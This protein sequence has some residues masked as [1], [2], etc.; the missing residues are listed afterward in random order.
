MLRF[1][2]FLMLPLYLFSN[3]LIID[4]KSRYDN[5]EISYLYDSYNHLHIE[6][7]LDQ[8]FKPTPS[9]FTFGYIEGATWFK[10]ELTNR[11]NNSDF[12]LY[13]AEPLWEEFDL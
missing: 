7:I 3:T 8:E 11:S 10:I 2:L 13:F 12:V 4:E 5:F 6:D 9:Q 1:W